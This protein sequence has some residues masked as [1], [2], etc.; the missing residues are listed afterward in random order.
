VRPPIV[1]LLPNQWEQ[2]ANLLLE[3]GD[4][5][6]LHILNN[7]V[8]YVYQLVISSLFLPNLT[9]KVKTYENVDVLLHKHFHNMFSMVVVVPG[10]HFEVVSHPLVVVL[11]GVVGHQSF[12]KLVQM[13]SHLVL[14]QMHFHLYRQKSK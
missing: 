7:R 2:E 11:A 6:S 3:E 12:E 14:C 9:S 13:L 5:V 8:N 1:G 4:V 10:E